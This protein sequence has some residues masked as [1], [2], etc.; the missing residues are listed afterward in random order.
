M[1]YPVSRAG[2]AGRRKA[3]RMSEALASQTVQPQ[4]HSGDVIRMLRGQGTFSAADLLRRGIS[5]QYASQLRQRGIL[6]RV[7]HGVSRLAPRFE[8]IRN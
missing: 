1:P 7:A 5:R 2:S 8:N 4:T 3:L 6:E